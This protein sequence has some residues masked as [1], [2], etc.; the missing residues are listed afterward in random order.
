MKLYEHQ[1][2]IIDEDPKKCGLW[3]GTGSGKTRIALLLARGSTLVIAP[4]TQVEDGNWVREYKQVIEWQTR[5]GGV[6]DIFKPSTTKIV[7]ISKETFRRDHEKLSAFDTVICDEVHGLLGVTPNTRQRKR[8][9]IPKSSQLYEAL[10]SYLH[11]TQPSRLYLC[12]ATI[13]KSPFTVWAAGKLLGKQWDFYEWRHAFYTRL[14][15]PGRE[16]WAPK[17]DSE[18]KDRLAA[19]VKQLGYVGRLED[20]F[21]VPEQTF[22]TSHVG[23]TPA[24]QK[25]IK[26]IRIEYP[27]PIVQ[28]GKR[29]QIENGVLAGN[30]FS[31]PEIFPN[32]KID[33]ILELAEE[34]PRMIIFAKYRAQIEQIDEA[35]SAK[36][37]RTA[38]LTGDVQDR[39]GLLQYVNKHTECIFIVQAQISAGWEC[40]EY[41]VM[42]FASRT[43]SF[44]DYQQGIG[45]ILRANHLKKNLYINLVVK[46][47]VDEAVDRALT[48]KQDFDERL[49]QS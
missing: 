41:P 37:Y 40:P 31:E 43:Y 49:Y 8:V 3:L 16:V 44:V 1:Q 36:N 26:E 13:I 15:M 38:F 29:H 42:V 19:A 7:I 45:R 20:Y 17:R 33:K 47:G 39:G 25:R 32:A 22:I 14:P 4:K 5:A 9:T 27:D 34:L 48:N 23:L 12:T 46:G 30:E 28:I 11:R 6:L 35:L 10:E 21:D 24:Q 18:T 2:K